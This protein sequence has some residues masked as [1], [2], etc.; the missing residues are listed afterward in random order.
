MGIIAI[1]M[2]IALPS[3]QTAINN[4]RIASARDGLANAIKMARSEAVFS[5]IP[6]TICASAD[7][8][9]CS[10]TGDWDNGW[11]IF[12]DADAD[13]QFD[14]GETLVDVF[15]G[16]GAVIIGAGNGGGAITF[17]ATGMKANAAVDNIGFCDPDAELDGKSLSIGATGSL[18]YMGDTTAAC[19]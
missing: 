19:P 15:Y 8:L 9:S 2:S 6:T 18:R 1:V 16:G 12:N 4:G 10:G 7:Q 14:A 11:I 3:F 13:G 17:Q 5:K